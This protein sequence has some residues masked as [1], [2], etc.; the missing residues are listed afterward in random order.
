MQYGDTELLIP[1]PSLLLDL[2]PSSRL[3]FMSSCF[4]FYPAVCPSSEWSSG[5]EHH[6]VL[7]ARRLSTCLVSGYNIKEKEELNALVKRKDAVMTLTLS[8]IRTPEE[9]RTWCQIVAPRILIRC[10]VKCLFGRLC[11]DM[12]YKEIGMRVGISARG[13]TLCLIEQS[14]S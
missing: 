6:S 2:S 14:P 1:G 3:S 8:Q 11:M 12:L 7:R 9:V 4:L 5:G 13:A 10:F